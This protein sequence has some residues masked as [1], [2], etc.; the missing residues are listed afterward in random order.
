MTSIRTSGTIGYIHASTRYL[1]FG[2]ASGMALS[3]RAITSTHTILSTILLFCS[4]PV[5][6][7]L[8]PHI[9]PT[10]PLLQHLKL[11]R[12]EALQ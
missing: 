9:R 8:V 5:V 2:T 3:C 6:P 11:C 7:S 4:V 10:R 12:R 1:N